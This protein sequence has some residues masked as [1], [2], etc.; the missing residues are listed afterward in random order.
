MS[1]MGI[2]LV[3]STYTFAFSFSSIDSEEKEIIKR[4]MS[5]GIMPSGDKAI[6]KAKLRQIEEEKAKTETT[7]T[8]KYHTVKQSEI[9]KFV[10]NKKG[11]KILGDYNKLMINYKK[12]A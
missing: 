9:E 6:D 2:G 10:E 3:Q 12:Y 11:A 1:S 8:N 4:L 7:P 5:Y